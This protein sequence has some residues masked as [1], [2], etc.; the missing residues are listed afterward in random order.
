VGLYEALPG[1]VISRGVLQLAAQPRDAARFGKIAASDLFDP[2][3]L[4]VLEP[5]AAGARLGEPAPLALDQAPALVIAPKTPLAAWLPPTRCGRV[6]RL[7]RIGEAWRLLGDGDALLAEAEQVILCAGLE[8]R[9]VTPGLPLSPVRGQ[10]SWVRDVAPPVAAAWGGYALPTGEG[11]TLFGATHDREDAARD[12]RPGD[13]ERNLA[14]L[15]AAL[16][17]LAARIAGRPLAGRAS[18]R[19]V[20]PDRLP[21][22]GPAPGLP[23]VHLLTGFGSRGFAVAPLLAEQVAA[24]ALGAPS[25]LPAALA[26]LVDP[27]RFERRAARPPNPGP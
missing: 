3:A 22:A 19:A 13:H 25:P 1:A 20:T 17:G 6:R 4:Q 11:G 26:A 8:S 9:E 7:E 18:V 12:L 24:Q 16:P 27:A 14:Q 10:A 15:R 21:L 23:G 2:G 5:E